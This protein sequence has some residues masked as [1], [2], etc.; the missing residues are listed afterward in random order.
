MKTI[1]AN[2][3]MNGSPLLADRF[4]TEL[5]NV[6]TQNKIVLCPP[7]LLLGNFRDFRHSIGAQNCFY[8]EDGAFTGEI[9]P[10]LLKELGC[11][12]V[13]VGHSER[14]TLFNESDEIIYRKWK[15]AVTQSLRPIVCIGEKLEERS[16]WEKILE[17][18]LA[19]YIH[20]DTDTISRTIFAYEP[21]WSIGTGLAPSL[22]DLEQVFDFIRNILPKGTGDTLIYG[23]SVKAKNAKEIAHCKNVDGLLIGGASL[24]IDEFKAIIAVV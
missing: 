11:E 23:G 24:D 9:S 6:D 3:K 12:Y 7:A 16:C 10:R 13:I 22:Q 20:G 2:W 4:V 5:N 19:R 21:V 14:R 17:D 1:I 18:Q 15:E 8:K